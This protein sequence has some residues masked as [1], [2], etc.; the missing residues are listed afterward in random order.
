MGGADAIMEKHYTVCHGGK[1]AGPVANSLEDIALD[2]HSHWSAA[3][4]RRRHHNE[5]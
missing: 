4:N 1:G 3:A 2:R 5:S